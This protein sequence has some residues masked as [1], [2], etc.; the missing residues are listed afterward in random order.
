[1]GQQTVVVNCRYRCCSYC[2]RA[3]FLPRSPDDG[4]NY[5]HLLIFSV[6]K[7]VLPC[8]FGMLLLDVTRYQVLVVSGRKQHG[9]FLF[10]EITDIFA[11]LSHGSSQISKVD[12]LKIQRFVVLLY[13]RLCP[14]TDV[15]S[16]QD[17]TFSPKKDD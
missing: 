16:A 10:P 5:I 15:N 7:N 4:C 17:N 8:S 13:D 12:W 6:Q 14:C 11:R 9:L 3:V 2:Y 1:M